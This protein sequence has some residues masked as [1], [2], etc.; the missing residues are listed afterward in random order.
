MSGICAPHWLVVTLSLAQAAS[1][2]DESFRKKNERDGRPGSTSFIAGSARLTTPTVF[3]RA[4]V[5]VKTTIAEALPGS[6]QAEPL[7]LVSSVSRTNGQPLM[8][9]QSSGT[10]SILAVALTGA[11]SYEQALASTRSALEIATTTPRALCITG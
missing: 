8:V 11:S 2:V 1:C 9:A 6:W 4:V 10:A 5:G 3:W 7:H